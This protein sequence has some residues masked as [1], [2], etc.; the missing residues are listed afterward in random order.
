[1]LLL[2]VEHDRRYYNKLLRKLTKIR[3]KIPIH[4][5]IFLRK[6]TIFA[7][8]LD[9]GFSTSFLY[10][11]YLKAKEKGLKAD[12]L[13]ARYVDES[14]LPEEVRR[15]SE[16]WMFRELSDEEIDILKKISIT[17]HIFERWC[18]W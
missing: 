15:L 10:V 5:D 8:S 9:D 14:W 6:G 7:E 1:M 18:R 2:K 16:K 12:L 3:R 4:V 17:E 11:A 13:Y